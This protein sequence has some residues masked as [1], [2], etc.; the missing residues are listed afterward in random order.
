MNLKKLLLPFILIFLGFV[1]I[2]VLFFT[3]DRLFSTEVEK[4]QM[5]VKITPGVSTSS[6]SVEVVTEKGVVVVENGENHLNSYT[7]DLN[8][9]SFDDQI[10][11]SKDS[12]FGEAVLTVKVYNSDTGNFDACEPVDTGITHTESFSVLVLDLL[13]N[14][15]KSIVALGHN[16]DG[17][18]VLSAFLVDLF[19]GKVKLHPIAHITASENIT[20]LQSER[21]QNYQMGQTKDKSF[22]ILAF[23]LTED[24]SRQLQVEYVWSSFLRKYIKKTE[25]QISIPKVEDD[26]VEML[27][28]G[29]VSDLEG[30]L[31]GLWYKIDEKAGDQYFVF[32]NSQKREV[33][34]LFEDAQEI[35]RWRQS[36]KRREGLYFSVTNTAIANLTRRVDVSVPNGQ[37]IVLRINDDVRMPISESTIWNG[38]Y[39]RHTDA[40]LG[41]VKTQR[42]PTEIFA[43]TEMDKKLWKTADGMVLMIMD[44]K[45][46][47][48]G[49]V[50]PESGSVAFEKTGNSL[51]FQFRPQSAECRLN[52]FYKVD[53]PNED[54]TQM[55]LSPAIITTTG[56]SLPGDD[57]IVFTLSE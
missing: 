16:L 44:N 22:P 18:M 26:I 47:L 28:R 20:I 41:N 6:N 45:F 29:N 50:S 5:S 25:R 42:L 37:Q 21:S 31:D 57:A 34:F 7:D 4:P 32:F 48:S 10:V 17:E 9:D 23:Y 51:F 38:T 35:Y 36:T 40:S 53:F 8:S 1:A 12:D 30:F 46:E 2:V 15:S 33:V 11:V 19:F 3:R 52:G 56:Y 55:V 14:H 13:G 43:S 24:S 39:Y 27:Q 54:G 49:S